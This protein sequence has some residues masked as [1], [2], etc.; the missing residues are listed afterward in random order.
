M[1]TTR[2]VNDG[3]SIGFGNWLPNPTR[4]GY[5]F[6]G[7][8]TGINGSGTKFTAATTVNANITVYAKWTSDGGGGSSSGGGRSNSSAPAYIANVKAGNGAETTLPV[9]VNKKSGSAAIEIGSQNLTSG[10]TVITVPSIPGVDSYSVGIPVQELSMPDGHDTLTFN[11]DAGSIT[12]P[13][14]M[15]TGVAGI[16]GSKAEI[17]INQG[18]KDKLPE[19]VK[20]IIGDRPVVQL[21]L[22]LDETPTG[23]NNSDAPVTMSI[24]YTPTEAEL[25]D[26]EHITV[27]Y[28]DGSGNAVSVP[29]GRYDPATGT[30]TFSTTHFSIFAVVCVEK[31]FTD[32]GAVDWAKISIE[33]LASKGI[34]KGATETEYDPQASITRADFLYFLVRTLGV[35]TKI[36]GNFED[37]SSDAYY[38][39]EIA[40]AKKLGITSGTG[41]NKFS[42]DASITR[43][44]MMVLTENA[45]RMLKKIEAQGTAADLDQFADKSLVAAYAVNG[46]ASVVKE[47]LIVGSGDNVNPLGNTTR[48]EAAV[49]L[50]RIYNK[51]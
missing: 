14:N 3:E 34:L 42:P 47:G 24:P 7:W 44:D 33:V 48:A 27:W 20:A 19:D 51:F 32:L 5:T 45:L 49:F 43:Q 29:S 11:T 40:I 18:D 41:N 4:T 30:V 50:Y 15:L 39:K 35:D 46:V 10:G 2:T 16:R 21:T 12:V 6:G 8:Y 23:W 25:A 13:L 28:I 22:T 38:Y 31:T 37:I 9:T 1:Y 26:P 36:G 17:T